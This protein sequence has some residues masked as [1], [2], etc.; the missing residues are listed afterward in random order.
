M[1]LAGLL[2]WASLPLSLAIC[3][4][5][6]LVSPRGFARCRTL[7][8]FGALFF[9]EAWGVATLTWGWLRH[10]GAPDAL[11]AHA[12]RTQWTWTTGLLGAMNRLF[13]VRYSVDGGEVLERGRF[14]LFLNHI[15]SADTLLP[16]AQIVV[17]HGYRARFVLKEELLWD[18]CLDLAGQRMRNHFVR[19]GAGKAEAEAV[20]ALAT[21]LA[22]DEVVVLY[23]EGTRFT[24]SRR[25]RRI[26]KLQEADD[27]ELTEKAQALER[28]LLPRPGGAVGMM[29]EAPDVD[30]VIGAHVGFAG[31]KSIASLFRGALVHQEVHLRFRRYPAASLPQ[32]DDARYD[33][34][35]ERWAEIDAWIQETDPG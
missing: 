35:L 15:S 25:E 33:W 16:I 11:A 6:D 28:V 10:R 1:A 22:E 2:Y 27:I 12:H 4:L 32:D 31:V 3:L 29:R 24:P 34:L 9:A 7:L 17:P 8:M 18:P 5:L 13:G 14:L 23:P 20:A 30:V 21:G 19:R 26:Q